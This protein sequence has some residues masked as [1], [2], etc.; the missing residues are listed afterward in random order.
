MRI[1]LKR[2][3]LLNL[4]VVSA[5]IESN[6]LT[7]QTAILYI[8]YLQR[9][10]ALIEEEN[11]RAQKNLATAMNTYNTVKLSS[12]VASLMKSGRRDFEA[13]MKLQI[14]QLREFSNESIRREFERMTVE[15]R[16]DR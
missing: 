14:P 6:K 10:A 12:D 2:D 1:L 3:R 5:N 16:S 4:R 15:L 7:Q 8:D 9:N 11:R 13:L